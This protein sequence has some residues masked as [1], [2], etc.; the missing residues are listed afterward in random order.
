MV[1]LR[2]IADSIGLYFC[3]KGN[4]NS[5]DLDHDVYT[6]IVPGVNFASN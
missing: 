2:L 4:P 3:M 6:N 5:I 1:S